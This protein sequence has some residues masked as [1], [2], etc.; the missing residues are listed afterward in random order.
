MKTIRFQMPMVLA[1]FL[2]SGAAH[3]KCHAPGDWRKTPASAAIGPNEDFSNDSDGQDSIGGYLCFGKKWD[4]APWVAPILKLI[5]AHKKAMDESPADVAQDVGEKAAAETVQAIAIAY[6][7]QVKQI[8]AQLTVPNSTGAAAQARIVKAQGNLD[9]KGSGNPMA[10]NPLAWIP[11][12]SMDGPQI[13]GTITG[14]P[15]PVSDLYEPYCGTG[16]AP[17]Q[18]DDAEGSAMNLLRAMALMEQAI[19]LKTYVA[20]VGA[21]KYSALRAAKWKSYFDDALLQYPWELGLNGLLFKE[22]GDSYRDPPNHQIIF[23]HPQIAAEYVGGAPEGDGFKPAVILE[24]AGVNFWRWSESGKTE[25][26]IGGS[27]GVLYSDRAEVKDVG[28]ALTTHFAQKYS[29]GVSFHDGDWGVFVNVPL[30]EK[31]QATYEEGKSKF[32]H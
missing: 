30:S 1:L 3:S 20:A 22:S 2:L 15:F 6:A 7:E 25:K 21:R 14:R 5:E 4:D 18:C 31:I 28:I 32:G 27:L 16:T 13:P 11:T 26:A 12:A 17:K 10:E 8:P 9:G 23:L 19:G 24:V 29:L